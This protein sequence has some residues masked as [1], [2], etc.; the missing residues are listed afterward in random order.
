MQEEIEQLKKIQISEAQWLEYYKS[1]QNTSLSKTEYCRQHNLII[2]NFYSWCYRFKK[3]EERAAHYKR[4]AFIPIVA[5]EPPVEPN[6]KIIAELLLSND[7][8]LK[9][10]LHPK[11]L[12]KLI[13]ELS[14]AAAVI[15]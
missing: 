12:L 11:M 2:D 14:D 10:S 13:R 1:W 8:R 4:D 3:K 15:R 7:I 9:V 6:D 5:K